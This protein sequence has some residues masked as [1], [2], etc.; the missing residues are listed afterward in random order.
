MKNL[1][2]RDRLSKR[3]I[4]IF[5]GLVWIISACKFVDQI[6]LL[7]FNIYPWYLKIAQN[8]IISTELIYELT[9][10]VSFRYSEYRCHVP[11][12]YESMLSFLFRIK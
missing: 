12:P 2:Y 4:L 8:K 6:F 5:I 10:N 7:L 3:R 1:G 9:M 11:T